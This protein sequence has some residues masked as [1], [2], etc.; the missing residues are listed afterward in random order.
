MGEP[1]NGWSVEGASDAVTLDKHM[2]ETVAPMLKATLGAQMAVSY[3]DMMEKL[4]N[5]TNLN[6][7]DRQDMLDW[8]LGKI[9]RG[10]KLETGKI[11]AISSGAYM[12]D[13]YNPATGEIKGDTAA[14]PTVSPAEIAATQKTLKANGINLSD[15]QVRAKI[16]A[17]KGAK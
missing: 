10:L 13:Q 6:A 15:E 4:R 7:K 8:T 5:F 9:E 2:L 16:A 14:A 11:K 3:R 1:Q 17:R 12:T